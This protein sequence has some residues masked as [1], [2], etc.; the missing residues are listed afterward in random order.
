MRSEDRYPANTVRS[1]L[2]TPLTTPVTAAALRARLAAQMGIVVFDALARKNL[3]AACDGLIP[4][5]E[6]SEPIDLT[7]IVENR[8]ATGVGDGW[9]YSD[10]PD[11]IAAL[12]SGLAA[13]EASARRSFNAGFS[14]LDSMARDGL[15]A[16]VQRGD[17]PTDIWCSLDPMRFFET[18]L[19]AVTEAY[20]A[21]PLAQEEIG[22]L[23]MADARGWA[24][25]GLNARAAHEP[26]P[27]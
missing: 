11:D 20:Y 12:R 2:N 19:V 21:H 3:R 17:V 6:R 10:M 25:V 14:D 8:L 1:I 18:L 23:G 4:Q 24:D 9:R 22:Y 13:I 16:C 7:S 5:S 26:E 15:L 27:L